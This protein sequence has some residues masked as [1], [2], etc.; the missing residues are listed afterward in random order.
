MAGLARFAEC[1]GPT[2]NFLG[3]TLLRALGRARALGAPARTYGS[4]A[5][6]QARMQ[7]AGMCCAYP[8]LSI[9]VDTFACRS[10]T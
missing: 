8:R 9:S 1:R 3:P 6:E 7:H 2:A 4:K 5:P 10:Y